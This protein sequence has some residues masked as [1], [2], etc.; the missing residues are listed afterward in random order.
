MSTAF[1]QRFW[2]SVTLP[3]PRDRDT[4]VAHT[5][6]G[7]APSGSA[8]SVARRPSSSST[9]GRRRPSSRRQPGVAVVAD[10][11]C[12]VAG[13]LRPSERGCRSPAGRRAVGSTRGDPE[14]PR[15]RDRVRD[16]RPRR[17][18]RT[19]SRRRR[20]L[21]NAYV[22]ELARAGRG[23]RA[24]RGSAGTSR[25]SSRATTPAGSAP[26]ARCRPRWRRTSSTPCSPTA[27]ATTSTTPTP[28]CPRRSAPTR[29]RS[30]CT[31]GP[32][33]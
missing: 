5:A 16:H 18:I 29:A 10:L 7:A 17:A 15:D 2:G 3:G 8:G 24:P 1:A 9:T 13:G 27:R 4:G 25:T 32:P 20:V 6:R 11:A 31:T 28:S 22:Q 26:T 19:R 14:G 23:D 33:S 12:G 21:I 30:S